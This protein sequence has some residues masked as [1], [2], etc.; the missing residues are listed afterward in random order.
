MKNFI[1]FLVADVLAFGSVFLFFID[2]WTQG[3]GYGLMAFAALVIGAHVALLVGWGI[4]RLF[5]KRPIS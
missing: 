3:D 1:A 5:R 4:W 2:T